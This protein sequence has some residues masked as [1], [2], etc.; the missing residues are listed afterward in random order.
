MDKHVELCGRRQTFTQ[1]CKILQL[2]RA[3][4][5]AQLAPDIMPKGNN[6]AEGRIREFACSVASLSINTRQ[7][8]RRATLIA[9]HSLQSKSPH[10]N[11]LAICRSEPET[12]FLL[13]KDAT[14]PWH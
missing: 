5:A 8:S 14:Q 10:G 11:V 6:R 1:R 12:S 7:P 2:L 9:S 13:K 4:A 3:F